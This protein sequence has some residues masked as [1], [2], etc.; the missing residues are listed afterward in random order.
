M[1]SLTVNL[2]KCISVALFIGIAFVLQSL[3]FKN[4]LEST[5][6]VILPDSRILMS[7]KVAIKMSKSIEKLF[8][9]LAVNFYANKINWTALQLQCFL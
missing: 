1:K 4:N 7:E 3:A 9:C 8:G 2:D 6:C 5:S